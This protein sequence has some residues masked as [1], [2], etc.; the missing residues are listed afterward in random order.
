M[1]PLRF[2][3]AVAGVE[4]EMRKNAETLSI[5]DEFSNIV[6]SN[7]SKRS[8]STTSTEETCYTNDGKTIR[9]TRIIVSRISVTRL[10]LPQ[11]SLDQ[12]IQ[13]EPQIQE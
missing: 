12:G 11:Q 13:L 2:S 10:G 1:L 7:V 9:K 6:H 8:T 3:V 5:D 4:N